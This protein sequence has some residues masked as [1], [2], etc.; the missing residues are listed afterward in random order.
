MNSCSSNSDSTQKHRI[1]HTISFKLDVCN[2]FHTIKNAT[3][4]GAA[5]YFN[6]T[7][8]QVRYFRRNEEVYRSM[9]KRR[10]KRNVIQPFQIK[11]RAKYSDQERNV[12]KWFIESR[13]AGR[14]IS[15]DILRI[16][17]FKN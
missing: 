9:R 1:T 6:L 4:S 3:V 16:L 17:V 5:R 8:K 13:E 14:L 10:S 11:L 7:R 15:N 2:Y 12:F